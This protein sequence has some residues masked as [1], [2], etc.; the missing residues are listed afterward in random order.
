MSGVGFTLKSKD[1]ASLPLQLEKLR[2]GLKSGEI[3]LL[4]GTAIREVV[5]EHFYVLQNDSAHHE[6]A[7]A[8]GA[9]PTGL[10][11]QAA[12]ATQAPTQEG[13]GV[14][15]SI[16]QQGIAQ[17]LHG[18]DIEARPGS[19]ITIPARAEAY[20]KRAS[21]FDNLKLIVFATLDLAALVDKDDEESEGLVYYWLVQRVHQDPDPTVL[22]E[23]A[24]MIDPAIEEARDFVD[25]LWERKAA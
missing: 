7:R 19:A 18:G 8:L 1:L 23:D 4:M 12:D 15:I 14:S 3:Q 24:E 21:E 10:Y 20:G 5:R 17:R 16:N 11:L 22:P 6:T 9:N 2:V 25:L 13:D